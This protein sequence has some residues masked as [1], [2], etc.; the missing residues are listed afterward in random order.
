LKAEVVTPFNRTFLLSS[1][2]SMDIKSAKG[3][4]LFTTSLFYTHS[5]KI[6]SDI[7]VRVTGLNYKNTL[8]FFSR[9][10]GIYFQV[11]RRLQLFP[12]LIKKKS[13]KMDSQP[14]NSTF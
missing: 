4:Y 10:S 2:F 1:G 11:S 7:S 5:M 6:M 9:G 12:W 3:A 8:N 14:D 13:K